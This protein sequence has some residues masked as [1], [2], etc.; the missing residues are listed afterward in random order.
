MIYL[1]F[2]TT[3]LK[4]FGCFLIPHYIYITVAAF[5]QKCLHISLQQHFLWIDFL[6]GFE[7]LG[8]WGCCL[9]LPDSWGVFGMQR[10]TDRRRGAVLL[11]S[12]VGHLKL[13][14]WSWL[15]YNASLHE[16]SPGQTARPSHCQYDRCCPGRLKARR[17]NVSVKSEKKCH[18]LSSLFLRPSRGLCV[19]EWMRACALRLWTELT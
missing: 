17:W 10:S 8:Q 9:C 13:I 4:Y 5:P 15:C 12:V 19:C 14:I 7:P 16:R 6:G 2:G 11:V 18:I 1:F 3:Y